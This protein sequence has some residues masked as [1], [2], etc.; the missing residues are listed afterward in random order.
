MA[1]SEDEHGETQK[2]PPEVF[3]R[4]RCLA[5]NFIKK[6]TLAQVFS[7]EYC[8]IFKTPFFTKHLWTTASRNQTIAHNTPM[9]Q[10][11]FSDS[12]S[13][14]NNLFIHHSNTRGILSTVGV[15]I[16]VDCSLQTYQNPDNFKSWRSCSY[17]S[18]QKSGRH[19]AS[20]Q[21]SE[22]TNNV[23]FWSYQN[24]VNSGS[25]HSCWL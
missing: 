22:L 25:W 8:E 6:E 4:K 21:L 9:E 2:Q 15:D 10:M 5:C 3:Y 16:F 19:Y 18:Y 24:P 12:T 1:A 17:Q 20:H 7:C 11:L 13:N 14:E 23:A